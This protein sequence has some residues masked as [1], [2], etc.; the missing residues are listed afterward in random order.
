MNNFFH[1]VKNN[2]LQQLKVRIRNAV[3]TIT[4]NMLQNLWIEVEYRLDTS[5]APSATGTDIY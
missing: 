2:D 3:T 4:H 1:Q 5:R